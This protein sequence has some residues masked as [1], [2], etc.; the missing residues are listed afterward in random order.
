MVAC[1]FVYGHLVSP[2]NLV[3]KYL[4]RKIDLLNIIKTGLVKSYQYE[5]SIC[6]CSIEYQF[7]EFLQDWQKNTSDKI[8]LVSFYKVTS[9]LFFLL[10]LF[11]CFT[12]Q[13]LSLKVTSAKKLFFV[14][15]EPLMCN[16]MNLK[17]WRK[18]VLLSR[19][20]DFYVFVKSADFKICDAIIS[21]AGKW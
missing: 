10:L 20:L 17:I 6:R 16:L 13:H 8:F 19:Y 7:L 14:I 15:N 21:I 1:L 9:F 2:K 5:I 12:E 11:R 4:C 18:N 3:V